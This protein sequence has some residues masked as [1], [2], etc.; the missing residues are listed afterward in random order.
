MAQPAERIRQQEDPDVKVATITGRK[1]F[2][3]FT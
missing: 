2:S 3:F 1:Q